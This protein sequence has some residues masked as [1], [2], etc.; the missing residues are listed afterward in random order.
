M[1]TFVLPSKKVLPSRTHISHYSFE[2][3]DARLEY[4][5]WEG[6]WIGKGLRVTGNFAT[7]PQS[8]ELTLATLRSVALA[9]VAA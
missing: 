8:Q 1:P 4:G 9:I 3:S 2:C 5:N 6:D 7:E